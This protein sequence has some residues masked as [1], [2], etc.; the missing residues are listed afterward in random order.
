MSRPSRTEVRSRLVHRRLGWYSRVPFTLRGTAWGTR[1]GSA[2]GGDGVASR[3]PATS[4][5]TPNRS[6]SAGGAQS[7][8]NRKSA[9]AAD[10]QHHE[11]GNRNEQ[12]HA[13]ACEQHPLRHTFRH[14]PVCPAALPR[15]V[16][17]GDIA[18]VTGRLPLWYK[19]NRA[20]CR[21]ASMVSWSASPAAPSRGKPNANSRGRLTKLSTEQ[22]GCSVL[23]EGRLH[24]QVDQTPCR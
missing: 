3:L 5:G 9:G 19:A 24:N 8:P 7:A 2:L 14:G 15:T 13:G 4:G 11:D 20:P 16:A 22:R 1:A 18:P 17:A 23:G 12:R 10:G 6:S 21:S